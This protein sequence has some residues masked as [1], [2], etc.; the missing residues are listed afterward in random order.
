MSILT[1]F[2]HKKLKLPTRVN[3]SGS[4]HWTKIIGTICEAA[5]SL[6]G[7]INEPNQLPNKPIVSKAR[8][9]AGFPNKDVKPYLDK[10]DFENVFPIFISFV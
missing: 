9:M 3:V 4:G 2:R 5:Q 7:S 10:K 1:T 8:T 6:I